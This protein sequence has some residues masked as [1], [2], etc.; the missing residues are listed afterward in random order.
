M[1]RLGILSAMAF[2]LSFG[3]NASDDEIPISEKAQERLAGFKETGDTETCLNIRRIREINA[4]DAQN[5]LV[6]VGV[7]KYY[8]NQVSKGCN[9]AQRGFN[10]LQYTISSGQLCRHEIIKVVDNNNGFIVGSCGLGD[11]K[12]LERID[13][14]EEQVES[15][16]S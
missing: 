8:L 10:R 7:N 5:F 12:K 16:G 4:L 1:I 6:R 2:V 9:G 14:E 15:S 3:A 11:F 13:P